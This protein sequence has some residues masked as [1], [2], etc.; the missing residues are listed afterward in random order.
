MKSAIPDLMPSFDIDKENQKQKMRELSEKNLIIKTAEK[1]KDY[2]T[3]K[4]CMILSQIYYYDEK[5][6]E[7]NTKKK[8]LILKK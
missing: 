4:N 5:D 2:H 1:E 3:A 6:K 8:Y 7:G